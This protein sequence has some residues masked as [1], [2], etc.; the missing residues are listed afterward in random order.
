MLTHRPSSQLHRLRFKSVY[1]LAV[2]R[3][4]S[5]GE[6]RNVSS[7]LPPCAHILFGP[8]RFSPRSRPELIVEIADAVGGGCSRR[9]ATITNFNADAATNGYLAQIP[10]VGRRGCVTSVS[11]SPASGRF[12]AS[13]TGS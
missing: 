2:C 6:I 13:L 4:G 12:T 8:Q 10:A 5:L 7:R 9:G 3:C 1:T 11:A